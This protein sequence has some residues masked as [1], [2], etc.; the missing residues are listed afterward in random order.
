MLQYRGINIRYSMPYSPEQN[1]AAERE[2][3]TIVEAAR[4]I[5]HHKCH[6]LKLWA[7]P[8]NT[9]VYVLNRT[10]PTREKEKTPI[11]LWSGS[12][13]NVGYLK[14]FGTKCFV[15][16]PK[17]RRQKLDPKSVVGFFCWLLR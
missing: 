2:N 4:S 14:V 7:E 3:T 1:G 6:S 15:H 8:V 16:V 5:L 12:S 9:A 13:F 10:G 17:Q 11:E